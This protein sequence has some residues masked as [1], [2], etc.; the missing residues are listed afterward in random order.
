MFY[1]IEVTVA[2][3]SKTTFGMGHFCWVFPYFFQ[4]PLEIIKSVNISHS[5]NPLRSLLNINVQ[6]KAHIIFMGATTISKN[7]VWAILGRMTHVKQM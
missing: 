1:I 4:N 2:Y 6:L 7:V 5:H 3:L